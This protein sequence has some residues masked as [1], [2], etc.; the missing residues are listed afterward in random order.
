[1]TRTS[2]FDDV[3]GSEIVG[4][5]WPEQQNLENYLLYI[6]GNFATVYDMQRKLWN[7]L[8]I[9]RSW[10]AHVS[11]MFDFHPVHTRDVIYAPKT[12]ES[13]KPDLNDVRVVLAEIEQNNNKFLSQRPKMILE[14][15]N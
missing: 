6:S 1:M 2:F 13:I 15:V 4:R 8:S 7:S 10:F 14:R 3:S 12:D 9:P 5:G 11:F